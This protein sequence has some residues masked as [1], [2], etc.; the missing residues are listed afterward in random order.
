MLKELFTGGLFKSVEKIA[1]E[2]IETEKESAEA[3]TIMVKALDPNGL[4][5]RNLGDRVA[6]L[7]T[8]YLL[9]TMC[10]L[11]AESFGLGPVNADGVMA[12]SMATEKIT[13]LFTPITSLFGV[14]VTASFGVNYANVKNGN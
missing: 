5:R 7:Y 6:L 13:D 12:V 8:I 3:K 2:W 14:I 4:M 9:V 10:L 1:S 11:I